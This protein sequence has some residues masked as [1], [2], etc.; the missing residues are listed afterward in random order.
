MN[1]YFKNKV[2]TIYNDNCLVV[3]DY[4]I[5]QGV[6][7]DAIITDPPYLKN[8]KTNYRKYDD[9]FNNEIANDDKKDNSQMIIDYISL[10]YDL[11][12]DNS[13]MA[14][15]CSFDYVDFFKSEIER[16]GFKVKNIVI[17]DK[18]NWTAG[19]LEAQFGIQYE[20]III[21][22]KGRC[23]FKNNYRFSDIWKFPR[24]VGYEQYHQNQKPHELIKQ[25]LDI[26]TI[27]N[28]L[29]LDGFS[30]S[31]TTSYASEQLNR[32]SIG[33]ELDKK[34]CDIGCYRLS[35]VQMKLF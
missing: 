12:K 5:E 4:L 19:D 8:Y 17:W 27:E 20:M 1:P 18:G 7:V 24:I 31:F 16:K 3:M 25:L 22:H 29:V 14:M 13:V 35:Q 33:I 15:F 28:D 26:F 10:S 34:Y 23:K 11:L 9:K 6:K 2:T 21:A 32:R 30:G